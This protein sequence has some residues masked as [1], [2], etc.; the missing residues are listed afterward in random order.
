MATILFKNV[1][2]WDGEA[3][4][5]YVANVVV[6]GKK[7]ETV[8]KN[9]ISLEEKHETID[10]EG[11]TLMP[12]LI[13]GHCHPSFVG[14][15]DPA[16]LG[17]IC[18]ERHILLTANNLRLLLDHGFTSIFEAAS[19]KPML[20]VV[21]RDAIE[22]GLIVGPRMKAA[23][24]EITNTSGLGDASMRHLY[25]ESFG[26]IA[27]GPDEMLRAARECIRDGVDTLKINVS[28]DELGSIAR[29][30]HTPLED[31]ELATFVRAGHKQ[32]KLVASHARNAESVK[33]SVRHGVD[34]I[35]HCDFAD[36]EALDMLESVK[37]TVFVGPAF[38]LVYNLVKDTEASGFDPALV[39]ELKLQQ[40]FDACCASYQ[41]MRKRGIR[42]V[43]GGDYGFSLTPMG[44]NARDID[45]FVQF[46]G[47]SPTEALKCATTIGAELMGMADRIGKVKE[48]FLADLILVKGDP[49]LDVTL[50]Q[51]LN[52]LAMIMKGGCLHKDPRN[53]T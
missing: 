9:S 35:Y 45:H 10:S 7:I 25:Q 20:G 5:S 18:P 41:E 3:D 47:Y 40:Q 37:D 15:G 11:M 13:D 51:D 23:S 4:S 44:Q 29:A 28:G 14:I 2:M 43:V 8:S 34:C 33:M 49:T 12:G 52:N 48:G 17:R 50:L 22:E 31:E 38:G 42:V 19:A 27:D 32:Q 24:P 36:E 30:A 53:T 6:A 46:F 26:L 1:K 21:A 16:E 39:E